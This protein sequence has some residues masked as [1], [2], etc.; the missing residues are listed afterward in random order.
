MDRSPVQLGRM[1][2]TTHAGRAL[3]ALLAI[4]AAVTAE[5]TTEDSEAATIRLYA[6]A[7]GPAIP[8]YTR[9]VEVS[10]DVLLEHLRAAG[11]TPAGYRTPGAGPFGPLRV[12]ACRI[13]RT[14]RS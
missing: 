14:G 6:A 1:P 12:A 8:E 10:Q 5:I 9:T 4:K 13:R 7:N 2:G 11:F 3:A